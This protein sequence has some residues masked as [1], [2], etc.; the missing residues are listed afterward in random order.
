[1][2]NSNKKLISAILAAIALAYT[3]VSAVAPAHAYDDDVEVVCGEDDNGSTWCATVDELTAECSV[4]DPEYTNDV[5]QGLL[6]DNSRP[7]R[8]DWFLVATGRTNVHTD[9]DRNPTGPSN[10][11]PPS[12][13]NQKANP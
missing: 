11:T 12:G 4:S 2:T 8:S 6:E 3:P 13:P 5:C 7:T 9:D 1:M 10:P